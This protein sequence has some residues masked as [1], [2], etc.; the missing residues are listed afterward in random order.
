[1]NTEE[2]YSVRLCVRSMMY[3]ERDF[4]IGIGSS[5]SGDSCSGSSAGITVN[6]RYSVVIGW[7]RS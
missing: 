5:D 7:R 2:L 1:V 6:P 4:S 3:T